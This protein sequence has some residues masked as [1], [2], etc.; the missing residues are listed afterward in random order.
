MGAKPGPHGRGSRSRS[1]R[2]SAT[3]GRV[4]LGLLSL[5][6]YSAAGCFRPAPP[7]LNLAPPA[8]ATEKL[9][10]VPYLQAVRA[11][12]WLYERTELRD[13]E[14]S[15]R[16]YYQRRVTA[17]RVIEGILVGR[18]LPP[19]ERY[20]Q[21]P[22]APA[23]EPGDNEPIESPPPLPGR[24]NPQFLEL[25][26][27]MEPIPL[28]LAEMNPLETTTQ[29]RHY[30]RRGRLASTGTLTRRIEIEG[31]QDVE[32]PA[33]RF[34]DCLRLRVELRLEF[35]FGLTLD[36]NSYIW[37]SPEAG[38]VRRIEELSGVYW[39]FGFGSAHEFRLV[40]YHRDVAATRTDSAWVSPKWSR[41]L[42]TLDRG[43]PRPRMSGMVFDFASVP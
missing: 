41:G 21:R 37:L 19:L 39:I 12:E 26:E 23:A 32:C 5:L 1:R 8:P 29:V 11:G 15:R 27:P 22:A 3:G 16:V 24:E 36:W 14:E 2:L 7:Q 42:L 31:T 18:D 13:G 34:A 25:V 17:E 28:E 38:E 10:L 43:L 40:A 30:N 4:A 33:G 20:L 6:G 9:N 35:P